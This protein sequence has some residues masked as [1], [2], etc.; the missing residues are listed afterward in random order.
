MMKARPY[1]GHPL[2]VAALALS[3]I[4]ID[5]ILSS[6]FKPEGNSGFGWI[7]FQAWAVY[8]L[9]GSNLKG[10]FKML[11]GYF[12]GI[13]MTVLIFEL[14][15]IVERLGFFA[16][17]VA[18]FV[19]V[20]GII[21]TEILPPFDLVPAIF[22]GAGAMVC[23]LSYIDSASYTNAAF[24]ILLY[25]LIGLCYGYFTV[26]LRTSYENWRKGEEHI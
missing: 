2:I 11:L 1:I 17:P 20:T 16:V 8:F 26:L 22:I 25:C 13:V 3:F 18:A 7:S 23:F 10:G 19:V 15:G 24:I 14:A 9:A 4:V 12:S 21:Y 6:F 5:Q